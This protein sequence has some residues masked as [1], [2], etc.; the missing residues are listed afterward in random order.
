[1][2]A[3]PVGNG[4]LGAMMFGA[5]VRERVVLNESSM[6]S[7]GP[8]DADRK[9][10]HKAL[11]RIRALIL[12]GEYAEAGEL[13]REN[14]NCEGPGSGHAVGSNL[15]FGCYQTLGDLN[16]YFFQA[17]SHNLRWLP[18]GAGISGAG[19]CEDIFDY[20]REL[21]L[22]TG[23]SASRYRINGITHSRECIASRP[24]E[25]IA[26]RCQ[27][28]CK[29]G[30]SFNAQLHRT[31]KFQVESCGGDGLRMTGQLE[32]GTDGKGVRYACLLKAKTEGGRVYADGG[33]LYVRGADSA[34]L[35]VTAA[36]DM[37]VPFGGRNL[38]DALGAAQA[39]MDRACAADWE[40]LKAESIAA[41][42]SLY[43]RSSFSLGSPESE[44]AL[45]ERM[46][47][48]RDGEQDLGLVE[49]LYNYGRYLLIASNAPGG[50][51]ANL[52]GIWGDEIQTPWNGDWHL[53]AQQMNFWPA[54]V[55]GLPELHMPYLRLIHSLMEPGERTAR[56]Y[57]GARGWVAH[58]FTNPWGYTS[59]GEGADWGATTT[60]SAWLCQ[61]VWDH[62]LFSGDMD[63]LR[64][65]YPI[66]RG[67]ALFYADMLVKEPKTGYLVTVPANSPENSFL[68][69]GQRSALCAGP[70]YDSQL[71]RYVFRAAIRAAGL[72]GADAE[73]ARELD[74]KLALLPPTEI[75]ADGGVKEWLE[76]YEQERPY[77]R[78]ISH[79]WGAYPGDEITPEDTPALA[80]AARRTILLRGKSSAGWANMHRV[81]VL[82]RAADGDKAEELLSFQLKHCSF[83]N[84]L[85]RT[86]H[87]DERHKLARLPEPGNYSFP[88]QI[89]A[90]LAAAGCIAEMLVQSHRFA[91][92][93]AERVHEIK[94][95]PA[96]PES[97]EAG[98][99][100]GLRARGGFEIDLSW[101]GHSLAQAEIRS[102]G[103]TE[104][105]V[106]YLGRRA[107][108]RVRQGESVKL[109]ALLESM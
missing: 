11:G 10:A 36:T 88:F 87:A 101:A 106:A 63:Y 59:P 5:P 34:V 61:H 108:I 31:E 71:L 37:R 21:D 69:N 4:R 41:H 55:A 89:D 92:S 43:G 18:A 23:V 66:L 19:H 65:A 1:M 109:N 78:H 49:L 93:F 8:Q 13:F 98:S 56:A 45:P 64:W 16:V 20:R 76:D 90:N 47:R 84:L 91:G 12:G 14:F 6:W 38:A 94:L 67:C 51:P 102:M 7:G 103:G 2:E 104:A 30:I 75:G 82:A 96:L 85:C 35:Y 83:P 22:Q 62:F 73:L 77:H 48:L 74:E 40:T 24:Y 97:W 33:T 17:I 58:V 53:D 29:G 39:D 9:G 42:R 107:R 3:A 81:A 60:G 105:D 46:R 68:S 54:E 50:M 26:L 32:N 52:Q 99:I 15:P 70:A 72:L 25:C 86:Y 28:T 44:R 27:S 100:T 95:L 79:L 80:E 57:Y